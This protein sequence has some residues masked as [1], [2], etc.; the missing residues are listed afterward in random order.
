[1]NALV[2]VENL[3]VRFGDRVAVSEVDLVVPAGHTVAVIGPNGSGKSTLLAAIAGLVEPSSGRVTVDRR[4]LAL[5]LQATDV[6]ESL[7]I[8]VM[9]TVRMARYARR[10]MFGRLGRD[11]ATAVR[12]AM[13]RTDVA[14]LAN[15]QLHDLSGGQRQRVLIAQGLAQEAQVLLLD[16][17]LTGLDLVSREIVLGIVAEERAV[18]RS[19]IMTTHS[20]DEAAACDT[21][22]LLA[23]RMVAAGAPDDVIVDG[24][25]RDA[26]GERV[27]RLASGQLVLDDPHHH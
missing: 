15:R 25:L 10:G 6:D 24:H 12:T 23:G 26:F 19:V 16:E 5:V 20:L 22:V 8:T 1:M 18:G 7:P 21:V 9:E 13:E 27:V 17:P 3:T 11:D 4:E 14:G 2:E